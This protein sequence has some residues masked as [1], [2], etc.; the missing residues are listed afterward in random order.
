MNIKWLPQVLTNIRRVMT[1]NG[2]LVVSLPYSTLRLFPPRSDYGRVV[3]CEGRLHTHIPLYYIHGLLWPLRVLYRIAFKRYALSNALAESVI[4]IY[5]DDTFDVHHWDLGV[6]PTTRRRVKEV[7]G[8]Q[9]AIV[10]EKVYVN[11]NC[12]F[13]VLRNVQAGNRPRS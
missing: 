10:S 5:P 1:D 13:F 4:P 12:V 2:V 8:G 3:S 9:F 11:T 7:L 6:W